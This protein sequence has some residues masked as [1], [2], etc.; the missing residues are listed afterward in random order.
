MIDSWMD[1]A[2][3]GMNKRKDWGEGRIAVGRRVE[4][5]ADR[6]R[7]FAGRGTKKGLGRQAEH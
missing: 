6:A 4:G 5:E 1:G 7:R 2:E 3:A